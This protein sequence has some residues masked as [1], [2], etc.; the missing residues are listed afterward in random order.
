MNSAKCIKPGHSRKVEVQ[1]PFV[2]Q[3]AA[4]AASTVW[5]VT[6][7]T[8]SIPNQK[9]MTIVELA[10]EMREGFKKEMTECKK[11]TKTLLTNSCL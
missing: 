11:E 3:R 8:P 1:T 2:K 10:K 5:A 9:E 7:Q 4:L 6:R